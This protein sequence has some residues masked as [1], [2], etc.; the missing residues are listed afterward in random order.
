M[1]ESVE[2][3]LDV[4]TGDFRPGSDR[5]PARG[6]AQAQIEGDALADIARGQELI[7]EGGHPRSVAEDEEE[8]RRAAW[9]AVIPAGFQPARA[10]GR[11]SRSAAA[12]TRSA[13]PSFRGASQTASRSLR[14]AAPASDL[15]V[16]SSARP[17]ARRPHRRTEPATSG[18]VRGVGDAGPIGSCPGTV[19]WS[20]RV[21]AI[22]RGRKAPASQASPAPDEQRV[23]QG[24]AGDERDH[25]A[26][27]VA[28]AARRNRNESAPR[29]RRAG[30]SGRQ[31]AHSRLAS[32]RQADRR[33]ARPGTRAARGAAARAGS[34]AWRR[35]SARSG[36]RAAPARPS[37]SAAGTARRRREAPRSRRRARG[38]GPS[39]AG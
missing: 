28:G 7:D 1:G 11:R 14:P 19:R 20:G 26:R 4:R 18:F 38:T 15:R 22:S 37:T 5:A 12:S 10:L 23:E 29:A 36:S 24:D 3:R 35:R 34:P 9:S 27:H 21:E 31:S 17:P 2:H 6:R 25:R 33:T 8:E 30:S 32:P 39:P 16:A 13:F